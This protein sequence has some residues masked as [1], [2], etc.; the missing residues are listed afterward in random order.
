MTD[1]GTGIP[2]RGAAAGVRAV[3]HHQSGRQGHRSRPVPGLRLRPADPAAPSRSTSEV[4]RGTTVTIYL[5]RSHAAVAD[6]EDDGQTT[7][8]CVAAAARFWWSRTIPRSANVTATLLGQLGYRVVR[9]Q[10]ATEAL[11]F[12][13]GS[14]I[15][16][17]FTD[18]VMPGPMDGLT[19]A[20]RDQNRLPAAAG[21]VDHRIHRCRAGGRI[22]VRGAAQ[23]VPDA[24]AGKN[25]ARRAPAQPPAQQ[26][27][28]GA[29]MSFRG[30]RKAGTRNDRRKGQRPSI[31]IAST[32]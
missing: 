2:Q 22:Q 28:G 18:I 15:D 32:S 4:G 13:T 19:L 1:T 21:S 12:W 7:L 11:R 31:T 10:S 26:R 8:P 23:A 3:L 20:R 5:P 29:V 25:R 16:L 27:P 6:P 24:G 30:R 9:A 17:V 14:G